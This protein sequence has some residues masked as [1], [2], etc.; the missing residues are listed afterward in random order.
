[1]QSALGTAFVPANYIVD[2]DADLSAVAKIAIDQNYL[3]VMMDVTDDVFNHPLDINPWERDEPDLYIGLYNLTKTHV[4]YGTGATADYQIR[5]DLDR[6]RLDGGGSNDCDSLVWAGS[7]YKFVEKPF[8]PGYIIEARIPLVDLATKRN[9]GVTSTD[10]INWKVGDR[11]PMTIGINDNDGSGR[12]GMI[13]Y[14]PQPA[15]EAYRDVSAWGYTWISDDVT[16]VDENPAAVNTFDLA[17]NYPNP[18]NPSTQIR[19]SIAEAGLVSVKVFDV[20]GREVAE[21]VNQNQSAGT[22]TV[23][24]NAQNLSTGVYIYKIQSGS[25]QATKKM[26]LIK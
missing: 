24:F 25:F 17:Q 18:F 4:A 9:P 6:V 16:A 21:L 1:M 23:D 5:F 26:V 8:D 15:E 7:N 22:Y 20:L 11:I 19:Y 14:Y 13:F 10:V 3:Y 12:V 2:G